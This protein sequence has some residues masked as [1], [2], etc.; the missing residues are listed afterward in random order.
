[1]TPRPPLVAGT[2]YPQNYQE[3]TEFF[4]DEASCV[5]FLIRCRWPDGFVCPHCSQKGE[6][7]VT[8]RGYFRCRSCRRFIS[9]TAGTIFERSQFSLQTWFA[10]MWFVTSQKDGASALGLQRVLGQGSYQTS[11]TWLHKLRRAMVCPGRDRLKGRVEIDETFIGGS[12]PGGKRGRGAES[13]EVVV[14]A[15]EIHV[16]KGYGRVRIRR[17]PDASA[18]SLT[19]FVCDV[20]EKGSTILTDGW[21]GYNAL[22]KNGYIHEKT[23]ISGSGDPAHITMP[24]VHRIASLVKRWLLST[25]QGAVSAKHLDYYLDEY[26]FRFNRRASRSRGLLFRRLMD[27]AVSTKSATYEEISAENH[28]R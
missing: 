15:L 18:E 12:K 5:R 1:M 11:W 22:E 10:A 7:W 16:P 19:P 6:P 4:P 26:T 27:Q 24:G 9:P 17:V 8:G 21:S 20:V 2:D 14:I 28:Y 13:K 23:I 3:L 25:H